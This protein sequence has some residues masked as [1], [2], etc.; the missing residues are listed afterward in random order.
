[1]DRFG[2][3]TARAGAEAEVASFGFEALLAPL[4]GL[5]A[6]LVAITLPIAVVAGPSA[7]LAA[8]VVALPPL[9][10]FLGDEINGLVSDIRI[11]AATIGTAA[12]PVA[13]QLLAMLTP[14][15]PVVT[16][17][18]LNLVQWFADRLPTMLP[19]VTQIF[20]TMAGVVFAVAGAIGRLS[21]FFVAN[22]QAVLQL[23]AGIGQGLGLLG[24]VAGAI[25]QVS[26]TS[27][28]LGVII[29]FLGG[30]MREVG[31]VLGFLAPAIVAVTVA[32]LAWNLAM[33]ISPIG[34][35]IIGLAA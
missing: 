2:N 16:E 35:V 32:Q 21:D 4:I 7:T 33:A 13:Q 27:Q 31:I 19:I 30:H 8:G 25:A 24:Q 1:M 26:S 34:L 18:G 28:A 29:G 6:A 23:W 3:T 11:M 22:W 12:V 17:L 10:G 9:M 15:I 20:Q 14:L 5:A